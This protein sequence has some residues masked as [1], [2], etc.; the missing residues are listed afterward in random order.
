MH[1]ICV[2]TSRVTTTARDAHPY[3]LVWA[4][5]EIGEIEV[6]TVGKYEMVFKMAVP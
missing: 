4:F 5:E 6:V 3:D 1:L 2:L